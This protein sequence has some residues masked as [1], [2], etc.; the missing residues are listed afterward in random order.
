MGDTGP[1]FGEFKTD[2]ESIFERLSRASGNAGRG[3]RTAV[4]DRGN[5]STWHGAKA[6]ATVACKTDVEV[7][8]G[9][10]ETVPI[11]DFV[12]GRFMEVAESMECACIIS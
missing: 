2:Y 7:L 10:L 4:V 5:P 8:D 12:F 6:S 11:H 1:G 9:L 3:V